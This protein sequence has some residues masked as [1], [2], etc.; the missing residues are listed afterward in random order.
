MTNRVTLLENVQCSVSH[1][2]G[3]RVLLQMYLVNCI[4]VLPAWQAVSSLANRAGDKED[5]DLEANQEV[6]V[7]IRVLQRRVGVKLRFSP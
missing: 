2:W 3:H 6:E 7:N 5:V 1:R 4:L